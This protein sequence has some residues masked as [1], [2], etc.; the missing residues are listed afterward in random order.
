MDVYWVAT[1]KHVLELLAGGNQAI[2]V[3]ITFVTNASIKSLGMDD[4][5]IELATE[6]TDD[7]FNLCISE[8][9]EYQDILAGFDPVM[10]E[11][12]QDGALEEIYQHYD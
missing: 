3:S 1:H 11:M 2:F 7:S 4:K 5:I 9:S 12:Q 6:I 8:L 10:L